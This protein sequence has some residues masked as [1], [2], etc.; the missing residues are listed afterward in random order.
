M[1]CGHSCAVQGGGVR[2]VRAGRHSAVG[3]RHG[4]HLPL[5]ELQ[6]HIDVCGHTGLQPWQHKER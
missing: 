6:D 2:R 4:G 5:Q 1:N 3:W